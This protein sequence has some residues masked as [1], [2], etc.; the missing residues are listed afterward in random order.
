MN[1][2]I[3]R[4]VLL[5]AFE[6]GLKRRR[7][8]CYLK[9]LERSQWL[10]RADLERLQFDALRRVVSR[11][12]ANCPYYRDDWRQ[13]GI[14]PQ[15]LQTPDAF[16]Q[17]PIIDRQAIRDNHLRMLT[18]VPGMKLIAKST[19]GSTGVPLHFHLNTD[20]N[21]RRMAAA[22]RGYGWAGAPLGTKQ[23]YLWGVP[24]G[25]RSR[26]KHWKDSL[27]N[28][29]YRRL[30]LNSFELG[31]EHVTR[32]L[33]ELNRYRPDAIVAYTN[34]LY[35]F[36]R[37]L[38]QHRLKPFSPQSVLVGAE[39]LFP[40]QRELIEKVFKAPV[41]ETYG[42]RE[43]MLIGA[44]CD[45][46]EGLH[47]TM[48]NLLVEVL[49]DDGRPTPDGEEGNIVITD[50]HNHG[51]PFIR[52]RIGDRAIAGWGTCSCGRGLPLLRRV[53]GRQLDVLHTPDGRRIPGEFFP[54]LLKEFASVQR[55]QV[56]QEE[57]D[58]IQLRM[59]LKSGWTNADHH[60][61]E[62]EVRR[63]IGPMIHF[64]VIPVDDI[65][66][67]VAGKFQVVINRVPGE[68]TSVCHPSSA[69]EQPCF[70]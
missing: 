3:H 57:A 39:K 7:T 48:E 68:G 60:L 52:Y 26:W 2:F 9:G 67:T 29:L 19:G 47:L 45:R 61:L 15:N 59:V 18:R 10:S 24:L 58:R 6:S 27:Y 5:P 55:F 63:V 21:D 42:S 30:V 44:E 37:F 34:P 25:E 62:R 46:H 64:D 49:D 51:M 28:R 12:F 17:W 20:S 54:H 33:Q 13:R 16:H 14:D 56:V 11:A 50:L 31:D 70:L 1:R 8:F 36:A 32:F 4:H 69:P 41:F 22:H 53:V 23:L 66:L 38:E 35:V 65:P 40:F 43:F